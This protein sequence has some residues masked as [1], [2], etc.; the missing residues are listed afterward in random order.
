LE[1]KLQPVSLHSIINHIIE[2]VQV[3]ADE[4]DIGIV[5]MYDVTAAPVLADVLRME[6]VFMNLLSNAIKYSHPNGTIKIGSEIMDSDDD[7]P[8]MKIWVK[9][10]GVGISADELPILF[11][12]YRQAS[13]A[14]HYRKKGT[15]LGLVICKMIIQAHGGTIWVESVENAGATF[16]F[17]LPMAGNLPPVVLQ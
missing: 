17:T 6:Q 7:I 13:N 1:I 2:N 15:G 9:D 12:K 4:K 10:N 16:Y 3:L 11:E 5:N 8:K 14:R